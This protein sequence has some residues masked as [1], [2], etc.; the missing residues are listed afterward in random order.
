FYPTYKLKDAPPT[1]AETIRRAAEIGRRAGLHFVYDG[2]VP[3]E[4]EMTTCSACG[5]ALVE[6]FG[7][8]VAR[9]GVADGR[10]PS[11]GEGVPGVW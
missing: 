11:C 4:E 2:N 7:F 1:P 8:R 5:E 6:R 3:G 10:C 9:N